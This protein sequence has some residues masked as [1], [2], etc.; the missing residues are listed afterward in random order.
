MGI[1]NLPTNNQAHT[2][3]ATDDKKS[4]QTLLDE[5]DSPHYGWGGM[6]HSSRIKQ[7]LLKDR[8]YANRLNLRELII[9]WSSPVMSQCAMR[10]ANVLN[11]I[12]CSWFLATRYLELGMVREARAMTLN[13]NFLHQCSVS[14]LSSSC[15]ASILEI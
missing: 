14:G 13:G 9:F 12:N 11:T 10:L 3:K 8:V 15:L 2:K 6:P 5:I 4:T 1:I 7:F